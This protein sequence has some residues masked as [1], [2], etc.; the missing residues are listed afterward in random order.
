VEQLDVIF[1]SGQQLG[2]VYNSYY[3]Q[4]MLADWSRGFDLV[5]WKDISGVT[6]K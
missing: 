2:K 4:T 3:Y 6:S 1:L 5:G